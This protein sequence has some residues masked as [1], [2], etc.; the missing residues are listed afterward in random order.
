MISDK[1]LIYLPVEND[2]NIIIKKNLVNDLSYYDFQIINNIETCDVDELKNFFIIIELAKCK[3]KSDLIDILMPHI[4]I[5]ITKNEYDNKKIYKFDNYDDLCNKIIALTPKKRD[6]LYLTITMNIPKN[7]QKF[8]ATMK[9]I[10]YNAVCENIHIKKYLNNTFDIKN[11]MNLDI[12]PFLTDYKLILIS[13]LVFVTSISKNNNKILISKAKYLKGI[14]NITILTHDLHE[15]SFMVLEINNS[16]ISP[17]Y[18]NGIYQPVLK[19]SVAKEK[20]KEL[21]EIFN[22]NNVISIYDCPEYDFFVKYNKQIDKFY[23]INH[24]YPNDVFKV[25]ATEK[26]YDILFYGTCLDSVYPFRGRLLRIC[27][28]MNIKLKKL[29]SV[30]GIYDS[31]IYEDQLS[32]YINESWMCIACVSNY[33]YYVRKYLEITAAGSVVLGDINPQGK[34]ILGDGFIEVSNKMSDQEIINIIKYY[35]DNKHLLLKMYEKNATLIKNYDYENYAN[36]LTAIA[37]DIINT[38]DDKDNN[39]KFSY[40][41]YKNSINDSINDGIC[42]TRLNK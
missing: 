23:I 3:I 41:S 28:K 39:F 17:N 26:K 33:S 36:N 21:L 37:Y 27:E 7:H 24:G 20:T 35:L 38:D 2:D 1:V 11:I 19:N 25:I 8:P 40:N 34:K 10:N 30:S 15:N 22:V 4:N 31:N 29:E 42:D 16:Y 5:I 18:I 6:F 12:I 14:K 32:K 9:E 13:S